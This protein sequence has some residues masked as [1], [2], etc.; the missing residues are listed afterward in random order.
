[1]FEAKRICIVRLGGLGDVINTLPALDALRAAYPQA[2]IAW[3]VESPWQDA[4]PGPPRLDEIIAVPKREWLSKLRRV[5]DAFSLP[6]EVSGFARE[7]RERE[8]DLAIDFHGNLRSGVATLATGAKDRV[9][10][11]HGFCKEGNHLFTNRRYAVGGGRM[12]RID[13]ALA[14]VRAMGVEPTGDVPKVDVHE[15]A[16]ARA[17]QMFEEIR[18]CGTG[19]LPVTHGLEGRAT[20]RPVVAV[21]PG[22]SK[23]GAYKRWPADRFNALIRLLDERGIASLVTWGPGESELAIAAAAGTRAVLPAEPGSLAD[24]AARLALCTAFVGADSGPAVLAAAVG[25]PPVVI[26]GP[27]DPVL[28]APR[29]PRTRVV[30][31]PM[32]CRP[33]S[34]RTCDDP[35]CVLHISVQRVADEVLEVLKDGTHHG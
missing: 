25:T 10:Y 9:G 5:T 35:K 27:K 17:K 32:E 23:F 3:L 6:V 15:N 19:I 7:L 16:A 29:H 33:C 20:S 18:D 26:F 34:K 8:F 12:H 31:V 11:E 24:L 22:T 2:H 14:L 13:R 28:Y 4:L 21:H 30:E 1:M